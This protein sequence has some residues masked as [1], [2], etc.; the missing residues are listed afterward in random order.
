MK[1]CAADDFLRGTAQ[2][3]PPFP[4]PPR[5]RQGTRCSPFIYLT[6]TF[7]ARPAGVHN[8]YHYEK[9]NGSP[10]ESCFSSSRSI[11]KEFFLVHLTP[12][13]LQFKSPPPKKNKTKQAFRN[14]VNIL[15]PTQAEK[16]DGSGEPIVAIKGAKLSDFGGRSL[17]ASFNSTLMVNPDIPE[18]YKL[19]GWWVTPS[20]PLSY[21]GNA[22]SYQQPTTSSNCWSVT[23]PVIA[24]TTE[25]P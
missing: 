13:T 18:A 8:M 11:I 12:L 25:V 4:P 20:Y 3:L 21:K 22:H 23:C 14:H 17:S 19:R 7:P 6:Q 2:S 24:N 15:W 10:E 5:P 1:C 16:F 9:N